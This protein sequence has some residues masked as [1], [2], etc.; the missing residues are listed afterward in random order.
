MAFAARYP[1]SRNL[2]FGQLSSL[3]TFAPSVPFSICQQSLSRPS[4]KRQH[5]PLTRSTADKRYTFTV[6]T[7]PTNP[8]DGVPTPEKIYF[9]TGNQKKL[10][11]VNIKFFL[12]VFLS[13]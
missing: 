6:T 9:A 13:L 4:I 7:M 10:Q 2:I 12:A 3:Q 5:I 11:E 1:I 8:A